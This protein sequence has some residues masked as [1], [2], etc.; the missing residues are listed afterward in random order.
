[1]PPRPI[2]NAKPDAGAA[3]AVEEI[4]PI[5]LA[6]TLGEKWATLSESAKEVCLAELIEGGVI[7]A[8]K[9]CRAPI[10]AF[11]KLPAGAEDKAELKM[12]VLRTRLKMLDSRYS[13]PLALLDVLGLLVE[14]AGHV[15]ALGDMLSAVWPA[16][17][18][19]ARSSRLQPSPA[20]RQPLI[21]HVRDALDG[22]PGGDLASAL[23]DQFTAAR[24]L[25][26][27]LSG[28]GQGSQAFAREC[29]N[30]IDPESI[31]S[32]L[33]RAKGRMPTTEEMWARYKQLSNTLSPGEIEHRLQ[34]HI[35][36]A[37]EAFFHAVH[38]G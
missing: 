36:N 38:R 24:L 16:W 29:S 1:M 8:P 23:R 22:H 30:F 19:L 13:G 28:L 10:E 7:E 9:A 37:A 26:A 18:G 33:R 32:E 31:Q 34:Q 27:I 5:R 3:E 21:H 25:I 11:V 17:H 2:I 35:V 4:H 12:D 6:R 15:T 14:L 20:S